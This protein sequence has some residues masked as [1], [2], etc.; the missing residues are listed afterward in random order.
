[1]ENRSDLVVDNGRLEVQAQVE[2][3]RDTAFSV[4]LTLTMPSVLGFQRLEGNKA[5][6]TCTRQEDSDREK[7]SFTCKFSSALTKNQKVRAE[8]VD[9]ELSV[10]PIDSGNRTCVRER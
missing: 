9:L 10:C 8:L 6:P 5:L 7:H 2:V 4:A 3:L 1:M